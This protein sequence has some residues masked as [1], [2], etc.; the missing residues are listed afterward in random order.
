M[1]NLKKMKDSQILRNLWLPKGSGGEGGRDAQGFVSGICTLRYR[2]DW[3][4]G[5]CCIAQRTLLNIP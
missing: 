5:T 4:M 2:N 1:W 3:S